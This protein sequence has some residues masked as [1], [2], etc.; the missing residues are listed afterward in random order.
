[1]DREAWWAAVHRVAK[2]RTQL[3]GLSR[4]AGCLPGTQ[5]GQGSSHL[6]CWDQQCSQD[7]VHMEPQ[8][9]TLFGTGVFVDV[10]S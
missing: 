6:L 2:S 3:R 9:V 10:I 8:K 7:G 4:Q 5:L 1:M